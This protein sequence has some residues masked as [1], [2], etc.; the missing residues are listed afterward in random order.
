[1]KP[2]AIPEELTSQ[3]KGKRK[4]WERKGTLC[5]CLAYLALEHWL[6]TPKTQINNEQKSSQ[7]VVFEE[8]GNRSIRRKPLCAEKRREPTNSTHIWRRIWE[9]N[10]DH[11]GGRRVL[12]PQRH[13][14]T[15]RTGILP[16]LNIS[17]E[18]MIV[19]LAGQSRWFSRMFKVCS[20]GFESMTIHLSTTLHK[21]SFTQHSFHGNTWAQ[22]IDLLASEWLH[23]SDGESSAP[24]SHRSWES[25]GRE[26]K[27]YRCTYGTVAEI[28]Q[29]VWGSSLSLTS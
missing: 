15:P 8:R 25:L 2:F 27:F 16:T 14:C 21:I 6:G 22:Q 20:T 9:S 29:Q 10:P 3:L 5:K 24:A 4:N 23:N 19:T 12:S 26:L 11:I 13:P 17:F 28:V 7:M 18:E 1:M